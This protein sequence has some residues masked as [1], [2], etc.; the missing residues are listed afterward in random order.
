MKTLNIFA[1]LLIVTFVNTSKS[2]SYS[3]IAQSLVQLHDAPEAGL[4]ALNSVSEGFADSHKTLESVAAVNLS[5][6]ESLESVQK[7]VSAGL[8]AALKHANEQKESLAAG[9]LAHAAVIKESAE[10]QQ[11]ESQ[12]I[13]EASAEIKKDS[14]ELVKKENELD[15]TVNVLLR[16]K[17]IARD[18]LA[19]TTKITTEMGKYNVVSKH[20][21]S[22]IQTSNFKQD[23]HSLLSKTH[24]ASKSLIS[25]LIMMANMDDAHYADPK[26]VAKI[27]AVLDKIIGSNTLKKSNLASEFAKDT[28]MNQ[29]MISNSV[30]LIANLQEGS[31][32]AE[33]GI[34]LNN[35]EVLMYNRDIQSI[36]GAQARRE[37]RNAF[38]ANYCK[39]Q[40]SMMEL[41]QKRYADV[42]SRVNELKAELA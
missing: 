19:G 15:E 39:Q 41:Y 10:N 2:I 22:F 27:L 31:I 4:A 21:V 11:D 23:L 42:A 14:A 1:I 24:T 29:E 34:S 17:N 32:K 5:T 8:V 25:T 6:C 12:K 3:D 36:Q 28:A 20:G 7:T 33:F 26:I 40:K 9:N 18:E 13:K 30:E 38:N 37:S 35:K 16:L